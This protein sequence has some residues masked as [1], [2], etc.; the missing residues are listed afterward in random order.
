MAKNEKKIENRIFFSNYFMKIGKIKSLKAY[1][2]KANEKVFFLSYRIHIGGYAHK[3]L[4]MCTQNFFLSASKVGYIVNFVKSKISKNEK[5]FIIQIY[6]L[7]V[8]TRYFKKII[9]NIV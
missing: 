2:Q 8:H 3:I 1:K 6:Y 5:K 7:L 9:Q 4:P